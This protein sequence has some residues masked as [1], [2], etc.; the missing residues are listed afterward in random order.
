MISESQN[1][2][3]KESWND[4]YLE[5]ICGFA[6][7]QG[8]SIYIGVNDD[9]Q[10]VG[11][12]DSKRLMEDIPNKIVTHLGI[13]ADVNLLQDNGKDYIEIIV[14]PNSVPINYRGHYH[15]RSGSTKQELSGISLQ[16]FILRKMGRQW[17]DVEHSSAT[18]ECIDPKAIDY[19]VK[20]GVKAK[21]LSAD[22]I[23]DNPLEVLTNLH[24][25]SD[26]GLLKN[27]AIL[28]FAKEPQKYF[29]G[30]QFKIG[31]FG[32]DEADL[33]FQDTIEGNILQMAD[34]V[35]EVL[36][37]K[38]LKSPIHY[39]GLQR[40]EPLEIPEDALREMLY[41]SIIHKDYAGAPIQMKVYDD[42]IE[43]WN[44]GTLPSGYTIDTLWQKHNSRPRNL[45]IAN[46]FNK[47]GFIEAW[48]RGFKKIREGFESENMEMPSCEILCGGLQVTIKR[49]DT[50]NVGGNGGKS[51]GDHGGDGSS[52]Q[53][54]ERQ[55]KIYH[56]IAASSEIKAKQ[57][58]VIANISQRTTERELAT[59]QKNGIIRFEGN[60]R[61][62][63]WVILKQL[64]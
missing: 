29:T 58:A 33:M 28:L 21:R 20:K 56:L 14:L 43:L 7:A 41:N 23:G 10:V 27:A 35:I 25:I 19:F 40:I 46:V 64:N 50:N 39:E 44:E 17:D 34:K 5:W 18:I 59:L 32:K 31:R 62:G 11:V 60:A 2:E 24:L 37:S 38:Y 52:V 22:S 57:M 13:V 12:P 42:T 53:L 36:K 4:K 6:N 63:H 26:D 3:Y 16:E 8:G 49:P 15:Y 47:A 51:G 54:T 9:K 48:G 55:R 1:I 61:N 30:I 45:N